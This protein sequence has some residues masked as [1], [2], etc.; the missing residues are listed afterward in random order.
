MMNVRWQEKDLVLT[1]E[2]KLQIFV[3]AVE[4]NYH[5]RIKNF[6]DT[7]LYKQYWYADYIELSP[8][9]YIFGEE[10]SINCFLFATDIGG[11]DEICKLHYLQPINKSW[12][13]TT[14]MDL[15]EM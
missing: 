14:V 7:Q 6:T 8:D 11:M 1:I 12:E 3:I 4:E 10:Y 13:E 5:N 2:F 9:V 15:C